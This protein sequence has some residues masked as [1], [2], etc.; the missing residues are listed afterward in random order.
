MANISAKDVMRLRN[1]TGLPMMECK[2]ALVEAN[3]DPEQAEIILR[4]K[5]KGKM[6]GKADRIAGEGRIGI[7]VDGSPPPSSS[8]KPRPTSP[9]KTTSSSRSPTN[10]PSSH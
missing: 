9:P 10:S 8:S 5:L 2:K 7:A 1:Q 6:E 4:K 3:G